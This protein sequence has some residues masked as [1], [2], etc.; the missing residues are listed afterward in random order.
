MF[1]LLKKFPT[2]ITT[3]FQSLLFVIIASNGSSSL[4]S[5]TRRIWPC[6]PP[7][8][9]WWS[10][11]IL[12]KRNTRLRCFQLRWVIMVILGYIDTLSGSNRNSTRDHLPYWSWQKS[13]SLS[14]PIVTLHIGSWYTYLNIFELITFTY[15]SVTYRGLV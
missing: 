14:C 6:S 8:K 4:L 13:Q 7:P 9:C 12:E 11:S 3:N 10:R 15:T 5:A 1:W 2:I